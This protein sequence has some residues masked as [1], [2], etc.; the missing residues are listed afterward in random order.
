M[1]LKHF[2]AFGYSAR[3]GSLDIN[4]RENKPTRTDSKGKKGGGGG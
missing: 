1:R 4:F 2:R 3:S